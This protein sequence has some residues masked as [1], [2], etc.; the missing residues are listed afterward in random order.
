[1]RFGTG[2]ET[3]CLVVRCRSRSA[4]GK[5]GAVGGAS[6]SGRRLLARCRRW[7]EAQT[8]HGRPAQTDGRSDERR[9]TDRQL[10]A[11]LTT[12]K[13]GYRACGHC[14]SGRQRFYTCS[15]PGRLLDRLPKSAAEPSLQPSTTR[16]RPS[17]APSEEST[18]VAATRPGWAGTALGGATIAGHD[19][20]TQRP[21]H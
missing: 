4:S 11:E 20:C 6:G 2:L 21:S 15:D 10:E 8:Q 18:S 9:Q 13:E 5:L 14:G 17:T 19:V 3:G 16:L 7:G 1:M 12:V